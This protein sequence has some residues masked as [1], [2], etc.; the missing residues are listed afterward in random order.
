[1]AK[2]AHNPDTLIVGLGPTGLSVARFMGREGK[3]FAVVDSRANPPG[4][5]DLQREFPN[6]PCHFG[7]F[8]TV[9]FETAKCLVVSPGVAVSTPQVLAA[10]KRGA[11]IIGDIELFARKAK[12]PIVAITGSN[13][14]SSV[15][16][17]VEEMA[18]AAGLRC[19]AIGN[20]GW[21]VLDALTEPVPDLYVMELSSFQLETTYSLKARVATVLNVCEDHMDRYD[22]F[23]DYI[24]A[25]AV[26]YQNCEHALLNRDDAEVMVLGNTLTSVSSFGLSADAENFCVLNK[27]GERYLAQGQRCLMPVNA[28]RLLGDH[29]IVNAL[30][31]L[32][33]GS[34]VGLPEAAMLTAICSFKGL[35]HRTEWVFEHE[36]V[37]WFNDSK[38]TNVGATLAALQGLPGKTVLI[39]GGQ[40]KGADFAPLRAAIRDH[41]RAVVLIGEDADEI[42]RV[43]TADTP[44][45]RAV[46]M[47]D[48]VRL[49]ADFAQPGDNVLLSPACASFDMFENYIRRGEVFTETVRRLAA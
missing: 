5:Q 11:E 27:E 18:H 43:V 35:P 7:D 6:A 34:A 16:K 42:A 36:G 26:I 1:M 13:G 4:M 12:A 10:K 37:N 9:F 23:A 39:A 38:G 17:L 48:A 49:A 2:A 19:Y 22:S 8:E 32:A 45:C 20:I 47:N 3:S 21:F 28:M 33:L 14:K 15:T 31:A 44:S 30:A 25:K 29:N 24:A 40:G 41:A 46:D